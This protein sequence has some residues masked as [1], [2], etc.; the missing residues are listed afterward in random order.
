MKKLI[1][2]LSASIAILVL[3]YTSIF[4]FGV[5]ASHETGK[6]WDIG[7]GAS[8]SSRPVRLEIGD[9][10]FVIPQNH[11]W[12][13]ENWKGGKVNGVNLQ[14]LL[15]DFA[16]YTESNRHE[17]DKPGWHDEIDILLTM[18][19]TPGAEYSSARMRRGDVYGRIISDYGTEKPRKL[20]RSKYQ[21]GL[22][23]I[24]M[25]PPSVK[26]GELYVV[27]DGDGANYW[28]DCYL[29]RPGKFPSCSTWLEYSERVAIRY[30]FS[31]THLRDWKQIDVSVIQWIGKFDLG[32]DKGEKK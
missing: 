20:V 17:F 13:R 28:V 21:F 16:P 12:S 18:H 30:T 31:R 23:K 4:I 25:T 5:I 1:K 32:S 27:A 14:V 7:Y 8:T 6:R 15:P 2:W 10:V 9:K 19:N 26:G 24:D 11:I 29:E 22:D 3:F